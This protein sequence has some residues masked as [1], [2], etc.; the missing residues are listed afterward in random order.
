MAYRWVFSLGGYW[1]LFLLG[2][3]PS[4]PVYTI[5]ELRAEAKAL[6]QSAYDTLV[7]C[8]TLSKIT[9]IEN[10]PRHKL[11]NCFLSLP[12]Q[13]LEGEF[14][15]GKIGDRQMAVESMNMDIIALKE[16]GYTWRIEPLDSSDRLLRMTALQT[17]YPV[18][19]HL[20]LYGGDSMPNIALI[21]IQKR[22]QE[23]LS[24]TLRLAGKSGT[25]W[26]M[27]EN[28]TS[29]IRLEEF[30]D[31]DFLEYRR[32]FADKRLN[33]LDNLYPLFVYELSP[34]EQNIKIG[35]SECYEKFFGDMENMPA[36]KDF[37]FHIK[38]KQV[39]FERSSGGFRKNNK[40]LS[41]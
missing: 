4:K 21:V 15:S 32:K 30:I 1:V 38:Y 14:F 25:G 13:A 5:D 22:E 35:L 8:D 10:K 23:C 39:V 2:C 28:P 31:E 6:H 40:T 9:P 34:E 17:P 27:M 18:E 37:M 16:A 24:A 20:T 12:S 29:A 33:S 7:P 19:Y 41:Q 3:F 36:S 11:V 26:K